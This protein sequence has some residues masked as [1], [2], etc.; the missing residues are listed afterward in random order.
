MLHGSNDQ[1]MK[2]LQQKIIRAHATLRQARARLGWTDP[3]RVRPARLVLRL[4]D[5]DLPGAMEGD[6]LGRSDWRRFLV[7][8]IDWL[9]PLPVTILAGQRGDH[10][11]LVEVIRFVHRLECPTTLVCDGGGIDDARALELIDVGLE[12]VKVRV[13]GVSSTAHRSSVGGAV[14][15]ASEAVTAFIEARRFRDVALDIE[16]LTPWR[17]RINEEITAVIGWARQLGCDGFRLTPPFRASELP[18]D[19]E[20]L[21]AVGEEPGPFNR[22]HHAAVVA[23]HAMVA[24][25]DGE[26]GRT[27][28]ASS[29]Q[30]LS[31]TGRCPVAGQRIELTASGRLFS[32]PFQPPIP[33]G[34][35]LK[36]SWEVKGR[37]HLEAIAGCERSCTHVELAPA[38]PR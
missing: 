35:S 12:A 18:A 36:D 17:G 8:A 27:R 22:T 2:L 1:F 13:G 23:L 30:R 26:P 31:G 21:D 24:N 20:V 28:Q 5:S 16:V 33:L 37:P 6:P 34:A 19:P 9:G 14:R 32:C 38:F 11:E 4:D 15:D 10:E 29:R 3:E 7:D 25:Q